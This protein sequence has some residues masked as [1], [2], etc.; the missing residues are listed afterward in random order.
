MD[1]K[2]KEKV[3]AELAKWYKKRPEKQ[4]LVKKGVLKQ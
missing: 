1:P 3:K 2:E 4:T